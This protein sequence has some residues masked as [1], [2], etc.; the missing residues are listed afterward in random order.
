M[1]KDNVNDLSLPFLGDDWFDPLE[2]AVRQSIQ[3]FIEAMLAGELE[4]ALGRGRYRRAG[5]ARGYRN[6]RRER[7]LLGTF[8]AVRQITCYIDRSYLVLATHCPRG[9]EM[10]E[11]IFYPPATDQRTDDLQT[12]RSRH[13]QPQ[14]F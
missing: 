12:G 6:G 5:R 9:V 8:G 7:H 13:T 2:E 4:R 1:K 10:A 3:G 14:P 11:L